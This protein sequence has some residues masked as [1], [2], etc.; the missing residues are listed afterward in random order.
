MEPLG[1]F[2]DADR[3]VFWFEGQHSRKNIAN[4]TIEASSIVG[5]TLNPTAPKA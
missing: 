2:S 5:M 3:C 1:N 4:R